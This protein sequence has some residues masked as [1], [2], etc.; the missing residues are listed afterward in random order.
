MVF[1]AGMDVIHIDIPFYHIPP[2]PAE[3]QDKNEQAP[4]GN[5]TQG[6]GT[7]EGNNGNENALF[8]KHLPRTAYAADT[9]IRTS[10]TIVGAELARYAETS[11][12]NDFQ[13]C[14]KHVEADQPA[15]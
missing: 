4:A 9:D 2:V 8:Y 5:G 6:K 13:K 11:S 7:G 1:M 15:A 14:A 12:G 3:F 10:G